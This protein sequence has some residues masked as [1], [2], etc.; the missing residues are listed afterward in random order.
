MVES[1]RAFMNGL[2]DYA[3]LFPPAKLPLAEAIT[4]YAHYLDTPDHWMLGRFIV[5]AQSLPQLTPS[6]MSSFSPAKPLTLS[7]L[8]QG[9]E[10]ESQ[11]SSNLQNDL[12]QMRLFGE[13]YA[14]RVTMELFEVKLPADANLPQLLAQT[15]QTIS[16]AGF[17]LQ[18][19][20]ELPFNAEWDNRLIPTMIAL[21]QTP[22][23]IG[24]KLRCGG[25]EPAA[26]PTVMQLAHAL[27]ACRDAKIPLKCTAGL[28]HPIR[29]FA[30]EVGTKMHGFVNLFAAGIF[31]HTHNLTPLQ[32]LPILEDEEAAHFQFSQHTLQWSHLTSS[33]SQI[34]QLR[35]TALISYGSCSFDEP[36]QEILNL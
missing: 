21:S 1:L 8:G 3:G 25:T 32:L 30:P 12:Q 11:F 4:L 17:T 33:T 29:H 22:G 20:Y 35:Q 26:F 7:I 10:T 2:V 9:G 31:A 23:T 15:K 27:V 18:L 34:A 16:Q 13:R 24:F 14:E 6:L 19:F 28:H 5:P 36:R